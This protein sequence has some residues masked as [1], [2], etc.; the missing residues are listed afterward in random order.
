MNMHDLQ[1][2]YF[3]METYLILSSS[4]CQVHTRPYVSTT[5]HRWRS[6]I[7]RIKD[8]LK[9]HAQWPFQWGMLEPCTIHWEWNGSRAYPRLRATKAIDVG[10]NCFEQ[11]SPKY[12]SS[13]FSPLF[14]PLLFPKHIIAF[15]YNAFIMF[16]E[17]ALIV[18]CLMPT[19][20]VDL[21]RNY[22]D[23]I[24][25]NDKVNAK[26]HKTI[27]TNLIIRPTFIKHWCLLS[28]GV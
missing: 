10:R 16:K 5:K 2:P 14:I 8:F 4:K 22:F 23:L 19:K 25:F 7:M 18:D 6:A 27:V 24:Q 20:V 9:V 21:D 26:R 3:T 15:V 1:L 28:K 11:F 13:V 12:S 17:S